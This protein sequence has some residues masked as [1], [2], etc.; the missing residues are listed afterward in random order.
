MNY[1][2]T[3][4]LWIIIPVF[5]VF[6][7]FMNLSLGSVSIPLNDIFKVLFGSTPSQ[8]I[9]KEI[10]LDFRLTKAL[11]CIL[12][13]SALSIGGLQMQTFFRNPLAGPD[14]FGLS[15]GASLAVSVIFMASNIGLTFF[16]GSSPWL[17]AVCASI[18]S[19]AVSFLVLLISKKLKDNVSLLI[20]G[21]MIGTAASSIVSVLQFV[22]SAEEQQLFLIWTF[23][24]LGGLNW[25]EITVLTILLIIG[26]A[27]S[28]SSVKSMN[29]WLLGDHY[30][31]SLGINLGRSRLLIITSTSLLTGAV[32]A[33]CGPIVF[34]GL[35][36]PHLVKII[37][38]SND[39][40]ILLPSVMA[41]G[42]AL[43]LFCDILAQLPGSSSS[44]VL[45]INA[46]TSLIGAPVV[47]WVI[48]RGRKV[49][50]G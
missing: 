21:L 48:L 6:L 27:I 17:V 32:T 25:N 30:A 26:S 11:T 8:P 19:G 13:G 28:Y 29:A 14:V 41:L 37:I 38:R 2:N 3:R 44:R 43:M 5:L 16:Y 20:I 23:G 12:A 47:I 33:F 49:S 18:G 22:S 50:I 15:A 31:E 4:R 46:I 42:A 36:V 10:I 45:P 40:K 1:F 24:N 39:H 34:V 9:W 7:F 35:A